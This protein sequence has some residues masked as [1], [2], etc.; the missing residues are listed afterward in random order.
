M[1]HAELACKNHP[2][3][4]HHRKMTKCLWYAEKPFA[5]G[6]TLALQYCQMMTER[7]K[8]YALGLTL[9]LLY[10]RMMTEHQKPY[11]LGPPLEPQHPRMM[12]ECHKTYAVGPTLAL[13]HC[14]EVTQHLRYAE[15]PHALRP[16]LDLTVK[17]SLCSETAPLAM[18]EASALSA[19]LEQGPLHQ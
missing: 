16:T 8:P 6:L 7:Q 14:P 3:L 1:V 9:A 11:L 12:T 19:S 5:L 2:A 17:Q 13:Q 15:Q 4:Q 18:T 10:C